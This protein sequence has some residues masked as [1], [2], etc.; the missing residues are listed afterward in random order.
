[1]VLPGITIGYNTIIG[2]GSVVTK[3]ISPNCVAFGNPCTIRRDINDRD[4]EYYYKN[5]KIEK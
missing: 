4:N 1:M 3:D 2:A 5:M